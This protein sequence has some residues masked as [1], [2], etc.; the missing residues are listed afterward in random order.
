MRKS[1]PL[2][3]RPM[4]DWPDSE[5]WRCEDEERASGEEA[6]R[7]SAAALKFGI[8]NLQKWLDLSA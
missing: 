4:L 1:P 8:H 7:W 3:E 6:A 2:L 5:E